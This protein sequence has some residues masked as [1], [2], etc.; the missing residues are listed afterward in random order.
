MISLSA[1]GG[2]Q[3]EELF[4]YGDADGGGSQGG[5]GTS[6][7]TSGSTDVAA[8]SVA[9]TTGT[10]S[11]VAQSS[12]QS[13][14]AST[15]A[16]PGDTAVYCKNAPCQ[17]GQVCCFHVSDPNQDMCSAPGSCGADYI[18][19]ACNGPEDCP[20]GECCGDWNGQ[21]YSGIS[22]VQRC[23]DFDVL[24]CEGNPG[25]CPAGENCFESQVLGAGYSYCGQ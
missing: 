9:S 8:S 14:V 19:L 2:K 7:E 21:T 5:A 18:T 20:G 10:S 11:S 6:A 25:V 16:G 15:G 12:V 24:M 13:S 22:C 3:G 1:C 4:G 23:S 17:S